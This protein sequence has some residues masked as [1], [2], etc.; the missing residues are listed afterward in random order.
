MQFLDHF[1]VDDPARVKSNF[2]AYGR[3]LEEHKEDF[4]REGLR[5]RDG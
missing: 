2:D 3:Y 5:I 4:P 1:D